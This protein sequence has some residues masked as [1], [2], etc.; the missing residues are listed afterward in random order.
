MA[1][2]RR[3]NRSYFYRKERINGRVRSVYVGRGEVAVLIDQCERGRLIE[4]KFK[5]HTIEKHRNKVELIDEAI[6]ELS[7]I[8]HSL[9][10][11]LFLINGFHRHKRQWRKRRNGKS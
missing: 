7:E 3:G 4:R 5:E 1:W 8:N 11:A 2:E 10:D 6:N 9:V